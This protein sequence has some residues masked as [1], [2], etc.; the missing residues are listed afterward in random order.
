[1]P[2]QDSAKLPGFLTGGLCHLYVLL[3][4][5]ADAS[6]RGLE[7]MLERLGGSRIREGKPQAE[8][9]LVASMVPRSDESLFQ[10]LVQ[11]LT[12]RARDAFSAHYYAAPQEAQD[13]A[14]TLNDPEERRYPA[15]TRGT[16]LRRASGDIPRLSRGRGTHHAKRGFLHGARPADTDPRIVIVSFEG[17]RRRISRE[18]GTSINRFVTAAVAEKVAAIKT[19]EF[20]AARAGEVDIEAGRR[21]LRRAGGRLPEPKDRLRIENRPH[22][23]VNAAGPAPLRCGG[24]PNT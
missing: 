14:W 7:L 16:S 10:Q 12:D 23:A 22:R 3:G 18:D 20:F 21:I 2:E 6:W 1:M 9:L 13:T 24:L 4:T 17:R 5:P 15:R 19:A 8:C 11:R